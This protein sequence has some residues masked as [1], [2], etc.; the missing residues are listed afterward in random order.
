MPKILVIDDDD[1]VRLLVR[2]ILI[3]AGYIVRTARN[4]RNAL[5]I[6]NRNHFDLIITDVVMPEMDGLEVIQEVLK[7]DPE[8]KIIAISGGGY[9]LPSDECLTVSGILGACRTLTKPF[10]IELLLGEIRSVLTS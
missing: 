7:N 8:M 2:E 9:W 5:K 4:G 3:D 6:L 10:G 1:G